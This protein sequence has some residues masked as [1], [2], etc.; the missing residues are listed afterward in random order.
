ML[1]RLKCSIDLLINL[2]LREISLSKLLL[3]SIINPNLLRPWIP[4]VKMISPGL[5]AFLCNLSSPWIPSAVIDM[6]FWFPFEQSPPRI[7]PPYFFKALLIP[8]YN[9][10]TQTHSVCAGKIRLIVIPIVFLLPLDN[11]S[12]ILL[13]TAFQPRSLGQIVMSVSYTHLPL[14]TSDLV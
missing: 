6:V 1:G 7:I 3:F 10:S 13:T 9:S 5:H 4:V 12:E 11:K 14:P 2:L 8:L